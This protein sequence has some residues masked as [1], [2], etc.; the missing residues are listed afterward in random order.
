[1][2]SSGLQTWTTQRQAALDE[3]ENAHRSVG[4][5]GRGRRY[6]TQQINHAYAV[7]LSSQFQGFCR[8]LHFECVVHLTQNLTPAMLRGPLRTALLQNRSLDRGNPHPGAIGSDFNRLG[9]TFWDD[10]H[11]HDVRTP[12]RHDRLVELNRWRNAI[13]HQDFDPALLGG[14]TTLQLKTVQAWRSACRGL[15]ISFDAVLRAHLESAT[16]RNPW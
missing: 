14:S 11:S 2:A 6:A 16:G 10:V 5:A 7:L 9:L 4:G 3:I 12:T 8:D 15:A 13:A 1:M